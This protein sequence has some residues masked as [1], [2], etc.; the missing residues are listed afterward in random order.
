MH[1]NRCTPRT[2]YPHPTSH[3]P[4]TD[5]CA[6]QA[7]AMYAPGAYDLGMGI[8]EVPYLVA[9]VSYFVT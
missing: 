6:S 4:N 5:L 9:Q 7:A 3:P 8:A 1:S 2:I